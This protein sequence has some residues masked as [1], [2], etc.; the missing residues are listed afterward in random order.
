LLQRRCKGAAPWNQVSALAPDARQPGLLLD[1]KARWTVEVIQLVEA[2][3]RH[4]GTPGWPVVRCA[5]A[6]TVPALLTIA[7][8]FGAEQRAPRSAGKP[9]VVPAPAVALGWAHGTARHWQTH[10]R[11]V[12][13][14]I[15]VQ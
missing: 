12:H 9:A 10:R 5:V 1:R 3:G 15:E 11:S 13:G 6:L 7:A 14:Q 2:G 8:W 4:N